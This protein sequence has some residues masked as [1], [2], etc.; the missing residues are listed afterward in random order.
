MIDFPET[1]FDPKACASVRPISFTPRL[2]PCAV[3]RAHHDELRR[4][5]RSVVL[6]VVREFPFVQ[7]VDAAAPL[8]D[9]EWCWAMKDG[10]MLYV[11]PNHLTVDGSVLV[12]GHLAAAIRAPAEPVR[13]A[14]GGNAST[15]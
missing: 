11:D 9:P 4:T 14:A 13:A 15:Q 8:C 2:T 5:Y 3:P 1:T 7:A 10:K 6:A 12:G